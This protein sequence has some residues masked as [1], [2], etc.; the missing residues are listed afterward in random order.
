MADSASPA[1]RDDRT[2]GPSLLRTVVLSLVVALAAAAISGWYL[3]A[4]VPSKLEYFLGLRFRTLAVAAGQLKS[5]GE[6]LSQALTTAKEKAGDSEQYLQ[7]LVPELKT[8]LKDGLELDG[9]RI[10]WSDLVAQASAATESNFDDLVLTDSDGTVVWQRE[11]TSPRIGNLTELLEHKPAADGSMF[12]LEWRIQTT[13]LSVDKK[14]RIMPPTATSNSVNL[15]GRTSELLTEPVTIL[16]NGQPRGFFLGGFISQSALQK[17]A[18]HVPAEWVVAAMLPFALVFLSLP[19]LKLATVTSKERYSFGD[20][21]FLAVCTIL[22]AAIGGALPFVADSP[23]KES[24]AEL[25]DLARGLEANLHTEAAHFLDLTKAVKDAKPTM[26]PCLTNVSDVSGVVCDVWQSLPATIGDQPR[27]FAELDVITWVDGDGMQQKKWTAKSQTTALISQDFAHFRDIMAKRT[28]TLPERGDAESFTIEP[29]RSPTT[30]DLAFVFAVPNDDRDPALPMLTLNVKPQSLVDTLVPPG[31]GFAILAPDGRVL[32]HSTQALSL[33]ENFP[34]ELGDT[35]AIA[36]AM[37][38]GGE[39]WWTGD[40]HGR[41]HRFYTDRVRSIIGSPWRIVTFRELEP[42]LS[43]S[44]G[45]QT[46]AVVLFSV[47]IFA[48][49]ALTGIYLYLHK[50]RGR[51]PKDVLVSAV[52]RSRSLEVTGAAIRWLAGVAVLMGAAIVATFFVGPKW[53]DVLFF[54]FVD[55]PIAAIILVGLTRRHRE[56]PSAT[57]Y[58]ERGYRRSAIELFLLAVVLGALPAAGM[59]RIAY[60][61]D[62]VRRH[63]QWLQTSR[64][65]A[66]A[67]ERRVRGFVNATKSYTPATKMLLLTAGYAAPAGDATPLYSYQPLLRHIGLKP[68]DAREHFEPYPLPWIAGRLS[69]VRG[70]LSASEVTS[71]SVEVSGDLDQMRLATAD[72]GGR[73][74]TADLS[75]GSLLPLRLGSVLGGLLILGVTFALVEWARKSLSARS[76]PKSVSLDDTVRRVEDGGPTSIVMFIGPPRME[77]DRLAVEAV[78]KVTGI[79]PEKRISLVEPLTRDA[80]DKQIE[81]VRQ[82]RKTG[83]PSRW[84]WVHISNLETQLVAKNSRAEVFRLFEQLQLRSLE[85]HVQERR[86]ALI[87]TTTVDPSAHFSEIFQ[88][89]R[90]DIYKTSVPEVELNRWSLV[91]SRIRRC[92]IG[93][94]GKSPWHSWYFY[95]PTKWRET[96]DLETSNHRLLSAV[97]SD[98]KRAWP[99]EHSVA[100]DD[101]R[102]AIRSRADTCYQLLWTSCTRSEK[103]VL[104]QLAQEGLINP[105]SRETLDEL[106]A[107]GLVIPGA[108]PTLFNLTFRDFLQDIERTDVV[109]A[110]ERMEGNGLWVMSGRIVATALAVGGAFYFLTQGFSIQ[111]VLP[112]ISGTGFLGVPLVKNIAGMLSSKKDAAPV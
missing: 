94:V 112:I 85:K 71:P 61:V 34:H 6:S 20:V 45:R 76:A 74:Y 36:R 37:V 107:K 77:K 39:A 87:V 66:L 88:E 91:L 56:P 44:S 26:K 55:A 33:E 49:L 64:D 10:A 103:L 60:R 79:R 19:F 3:F 99:H 73:H 98:L 24:D 11:R 22:L 97:G 92:Y 110:W 30:S 27:G 75:A 105:K 4:Y 63:A 46:A 18:R 29:L 35:S 50:R 59:A 53:L 41:E 86:V 21:V 89:E 9:H 67:R 93:P 57:A 95:D 1:K 106:V 14:A 13:P 82:L 69:W 111:S 80:A 81:D 28:W 83:D 54:V 8:N 25:R 102:R 70:L 2:S 51:S 101:L 17:E 31:F 48:M 38:A 7:A 108:A 5:K 12:S 40:Y 15:D 109:Q 96:L 42:L 58:D 78:E 16:V 68:D 47:N 43:F 84:L 90:Q 100:M 32:F 72:A 65:E 104:I 23:T 62:D 52:M